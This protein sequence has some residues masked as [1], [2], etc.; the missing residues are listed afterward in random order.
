MRKIKIAA[1]IIVLAS[2]FT[3]LFAVNVIASEIVPI[4]E[5]ENV[6]TRSLV[7]RGLLHIYKNKAMAKSGVFGDDI[8][9]EK[10]DFQRVLNISDS[11]LDT[12]TITRAPTNTDGELRIGSSKIVSGQKIL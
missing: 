8:Y 7:S 11:Q 2:L 5:T 10:S 3:L 1:L 6:D 4:S 12:L 9:F